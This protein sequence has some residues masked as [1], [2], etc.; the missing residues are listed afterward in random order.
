[1]VERKERQSSDRERKKI[2]GGM[3][4]GFGERNRDTYTDND[5]EVKGPWC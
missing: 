2:K 5:K 1:V 3:K 4:A